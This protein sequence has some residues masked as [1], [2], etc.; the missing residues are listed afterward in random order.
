MPVI[1]VHRRRLE[2]LLGR[3]TEDKDLENILFRLKSEM[4]LL[5]ED[6]IEIEVNTDRP[7]LFAPEGIARA[8]KGLLGIQT[9]LPKLRVGESRLKA[10]VDYVPTRPYIG[11]VIV[12]N[13]YL[14]EKVLEELIQFQ[15]KLHVTLG[16]KRRKV[17]IGIH[18][19][20]KLPRGDLVYTMA[21][22]DTRMKPLGLDKE[23]SIRK[24]LRDTPQGKLYG[25]ISLEGNRHP[26]IYAGS[27][28][29]S[30]PPVINS[31]VTRLEPG[32]RNLLI[33]VTG[34]SAQHVYKTLD[35]LSSVLNERDGT[36]IKKVVLSMKSGT[37]ETPM[38]KR[39][40]VILDLP[41]IQEKLG[42]PLSVREALDLLGRIR[43]E[44]DII[45]NET[46][47]VTVPEYRTDILHKIDVVEDIAIA[48]GYD[49]IPIVKPSRI[50][51]PNKK[52]IMEFIHA[53]R[54]LTIGQ[55]FIET[56]S[57]TLI[58]EETILFQTPMQTP[59]A[60]KNPI[61][62]SM[63]YVRNSILPS[64]L[65]VL[66]ESQSHPKPIRVFE[67]GEIAYVGRKGV[68][69]HRAIG[70]AIMK[71]YAGFEEIQSPIYNILEEIGLTP[72]SAP[73]ESPYFI[74]GRAAWIKAEDIR[75][76]MAGEIHPSVLEK[77]G[78][79]YPV[80]AGEINID[81]IFSILKT[82]VLG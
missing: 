36:F 13:Y 41:Y 68:E 34:T 16:R 64:L 81:L 14:D 11:F 42:F 49:R 3:K 28:I 23:V 74:D 10:R 53:L 43:M 80:V 51:R 82:N 24:V 7:D 5:E 63:S 56:N 71:D 8:I 52:T 79:K 38:L 25:S 31:E 33:D 70:L 17:A 44:A 73:A 35:I 30:L 2:E 29:I 1:R 19:L 47:K 6:I 55:G 18:D 37:I 27:E 59:L 20:D 65:H 72:S 40:E 78:I 76:G 54:D 50:I 39:E 22:L 77:F 9:G 75:V 12:E 15:E 62:E 69:I 58:G 45:D 60:L 26:A 66:R 21:S 32:T 61:S 67:I 48:Y 4:N 57:Y 46:L